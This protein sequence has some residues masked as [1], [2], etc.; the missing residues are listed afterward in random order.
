MLHADIGLSFWG[1]INS[2]TGMVIDR[3]HPLH[4]ACVA[5]KI[6][7]I[8]SGRGSCTGSAV[9]LELIMGGKAPA[10]LIFHEEETILPLAAMLS[11]ALFQRSLP[12]LRLNR[13]S[14]AALSAAK[15]VTVNG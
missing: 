5:G 14:F 4:G 13:A 15:Q 12:M 1:G 2:E 7:A 8:P 9:L 10:A 11:N 6:L 3:L